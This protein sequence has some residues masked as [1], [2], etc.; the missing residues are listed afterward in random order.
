MAAIC[1]RLIHDLEARHA[2]A[3]VGDEGADKLFAALQ[4]LLREHG[5]KNRADQ[6]RLAV[7]DAAGLLIQQPAHLLGLG[8]RGVA[9]AMLRRCRLRPQRE[10]AQ[11][12]P[13]FR[14]HLIP[15][16]CVFF[17]QPEE[18]GGREER[19]CESRTQV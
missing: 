8:Q 13:F 1:R 5:A 2:R 19:P 12:N 7:A 17:C 3:A 11:Q 18:I 16:G 4:R 9:A 10:R 14:L 15:P 6:R